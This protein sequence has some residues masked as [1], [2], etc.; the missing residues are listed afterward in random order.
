MTTGNAEYHGRKKA[1]RAYPGYWSLALHI[2]NI[3]LRL[4]THF[5]TDKF[6]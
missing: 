2:L 6:N 3:I 5:F 4:S 1:L